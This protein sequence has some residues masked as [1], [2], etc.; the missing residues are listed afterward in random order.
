[1]SPEMVEIGKINKCE[2]RRA[3]NGGYIIESYD[4][5]GPHIFKT[6]DE[7]VNELR[8]LFGEKKPEQI[9]FADGTGTTAPYGDT[10][11]AGSD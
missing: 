7:L 11:A 6:F 4:L 5:S 1:M 10:T 3:W 8:E 9:P 2:I